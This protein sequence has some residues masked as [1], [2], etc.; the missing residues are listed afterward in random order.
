[1]CELMC[2]L[3]CQLMSYADILNE[4]LSTSDGI[5]RLIANTNVTDM[6]STNEEAQEILDQLIEKITSL[7]D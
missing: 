3:M 5:D 6:A 4:N 1:M 2:Q 7:L